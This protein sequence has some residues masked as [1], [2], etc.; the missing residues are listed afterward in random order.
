MEQLKN[1]RLTVEISSHGAELQSIRNAEGHEYLWQGDDKYWP[2]RSPLL[3]P[4]VCGLWK[5]E[6]RIDGKTYSLPRHG[7]ARDMDFDVIDKTD[8]M[9]TY[10][11]VSDED[12]LKVYP[13]E[14]ELNVTYVL[15]DDAIDVIWSVRN[16]GKE[17]MHFQIGGHPAFNLPGVKEGEPMKGSILFDNTQ[18]LTR[19][20]GNTGGCIKPERYDLATDHGTWAFNEESFA[21][22][23]V[24]LDKSQVGL[25]V[26]LDAEANP[27]IGLS[28]DAPCVGIW[29]PY[30]KNAP[31]VCIEPWYGVHD[32]AEYTG[33]FKD[34]YLMNHLLPGA[35]FVSNYEIKIF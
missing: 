22:D 9:V 24:I 12:T 27:V 33:E 7:F 4:I 34:K 15:N 8:T 30:G 23:A 17:E 5:N 6:Y 29:S 21:D 28:F 1:D 2:R 32:W 31:F 3:F 11:L 18:P 26:L 19:I 20:I 14:F 16:P 35:T 10:E 25:S 13:Y